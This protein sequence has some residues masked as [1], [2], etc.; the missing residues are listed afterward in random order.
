MLTQKTLKS[1]IARLFDSGTPRMSSTSTLRATAFGFAAAAAAIALLIGGARVR[2]DEVKPVAAA[3]AAAQQDAPA[4][5]PPPGK[6]AE[7]RV[8][9]VVDGVTP[10]RVLSK[11]DPKYTEDAKAAKVEGSVTLS[12][13]IAPDGIPH[14]INV[15]TGLDP[16]LDLEAVKAVQKWHFQPGTKEGEPVPVRAVIQINF[17]LL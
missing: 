15:V 1:R 7:E 2:A 17:K 12:V 6:P 11:E 16:G 9:R 8:Y 4:P 13:V 14:D 3:P 10:P 5:P